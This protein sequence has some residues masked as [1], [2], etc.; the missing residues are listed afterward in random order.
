MNLIRL[1]VLMG[2]F[3]LG[4]YLTFSFFPGGGS[5]LTADEFI[6]AVQPG[7]IILDVRTP[8][9]F[10]TG[11][12][13]GAINLDVSSP[14]F[15]RIAARLPKDRPIYTYCA[16]GVRSDEAAEAL[17]LMGYPVVDNVG[18]FDDLVASGAA[19]AAPEASGIAP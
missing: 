1:F 4:L 15:Q 10:E 3:G 9:E 12:L 7:D 17:R 19:V 11:H 5:Q 14:S 6:R 16:S 2:L 18:S 13:E 8:E